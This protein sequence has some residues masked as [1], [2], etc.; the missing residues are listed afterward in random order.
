[1]QRITTAEPTDDIIEVGIAALKAA[2]NGAPEKAEAQEE[3][4]QESETPEELNDEP[5]AAPE[6]PVDEEN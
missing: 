1:M 5:A 2:L 6:Q 3:T 4:V